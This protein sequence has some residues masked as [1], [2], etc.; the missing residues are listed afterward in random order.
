MTTDPL[1]WLHDPPCRALPVETFF[2]VIGRDRHGREVYPP[3][4]VACCAGCPHVDPCLDEALR[5]PR[6]WD[7]GY[8]AGCGPEVRAR[9]RVALAPVDWRAS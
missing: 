1:A 8:R 7:Q 5:A 6:E 3:A 4:A 9:M 2:A